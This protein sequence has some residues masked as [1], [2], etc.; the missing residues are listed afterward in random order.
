VLVRGDTV[1]DVMVDALHDDD[2]D[3]VLLLVDLA[4][5]D[6]AV[7][8][9]AAPAFPFERELVEMARLVEE[10]D[11]RDR[12]VVALL[13][14]DLEWLRVDWPTFP[15]EVLRSGRCIIAAARAAARAAAE[16]RAPA[17]TPG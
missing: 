14:C 5:D 9:E 12:D 6:D 1:E 11:G 17:V 10:L 2:D 13:R 8:D 15:G 4:D 3:D 7:G 16:H